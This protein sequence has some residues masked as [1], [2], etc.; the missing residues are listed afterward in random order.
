MIEVTNV[1]GSNTQDLVPAT[2][3]DPKLRKNVKEM[4]AVLKL[5]II[6]LSNIQSFGKS[7]STDKTL[8]IEEIL[9]LN[10]VGIAVFCETWLKDETIDRLPFKLYQKFHH[11]RKNVLRSSGGV[12]ILVENSLPASKLDIQIP[13][14][15]ECIW[16]TV[17]PEWLPRSVSNIVIC[18]V[19]YPGLN[20]LYSPK[21]EDLIFHII[22]SVQYLKRKYVNPLFFIMGD[23][24][25]LPIDSIIAVCEFKQVVKVIT[26]GDATLDLIFTNKS[27]SLFEEPVSLPK[28]GDGDHFP[29][30][31]LPKNYIPP[32]NK[33]KTVNMRK[34]PKSTKNHFGAWISSFDW[35]QLYGIS[36]VNEK[37]SYFSVLLWKVINIYFPLLKFV[38]S[39]TDKEWVT[40]KIKDLFSK[41]QKA[42]FEGK[43]ETRDS[44]AKIIKKEIKVAKREFHESKVGVFENTDPKEWY[45]HINNIINN[46][47]FAEIN[48]NNIP[49][50]AQKTPSEQKCIINE[51]FANICKKYPPLEYDFITTGASN[52]VS[53]PETTELET[54]KM[55]LKFSKKSLGATDFPRKILQEFAVELATPYCNIINC[56][57]RSSVFPEEYKKAEITPIPKVNPPMTLSD[58]RP[59]S[60]T[61]VGGKMIETV[62]M[63]EL[64][65]DLTGKLDSDQYGNV[66]G[67]STTHYL[68]SLTNEAFVSTNRGDATT[69]ITIDYSKAFDYVDHSILIEKLVKLGVRTILINLIISFLKGRSHCTKILGEVSSFLNI[70]CGVPQGTC[71]G[72]KLFV[73][74][75]D[76]KKCSFVSTHKFVD[77]KT[78]SYSYS[79]DPTEILQNA[80]DIESEETRKDK[81][82]INGTKCH[83]ITFNF[84]QKNK[85]PQ[86]LNLNGITVDNCDTIKL[87]GIKISKDLKWAENTKHICSKVR[88]KIYILSKLKKFGLKTHELLVTW[89]TILRP[90]TEYAV[91]LWHPGLTKGDSEKLES[92]QK[93]AIGIILGVKYIDNRRYYKFNNETLKYEVALEKTGLV[94]LSDRREILTNK[95]AL[96]IVNSE[97]HQNMFQFKQK[98]TQTRSNALFQEERYYSERFRNSS[99]P[100]MTRLLNNVL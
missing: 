9:V 5:P 60:K 43:F 6:L 62:I 68:I 96:Q 14:N 69:A 53:I 38:I 10:N 26:R 100:Y 55:L 31:Y 65:K 3:L 97:R 30:L 20:S 80:L 83:A 7:E 94:P 36:D 73:I 64:E 13:D 15:I 25:D 59:I 19:Y 47:K 50:L 74:L 4:H 16:V 98:K 77:D 66:K 99:V 49:E 91:P 57:I 2:S 27:N 28:I 29:V 84:S 12:S 1:N 42:H 92:M 82:I 54:Y 37:I 11:I 61:P 86:N 33:K 71:S 78:L 51:Y 21:Q 40:P 81:M 52:N 39:S 34:F 89:K 17:R 87:L 56:S 90:L 35:G 48:L 46:G 70:T 23:F 8:E 88:K 18:G 44:L 75:I 45:R 63:K 72:P 24:N 79:G 76:G 95:F 67:S 22:T 58:L 93:W 32:K 41:R 85:L